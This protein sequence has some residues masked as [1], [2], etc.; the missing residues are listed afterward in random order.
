MKIQLEQV[1]YVQKGITVQVEQV[2]LYRALL[3]DFLI[4]LDWKWKVNVEVV[5]LDI[6]VEP[7]AWIRH[8]VC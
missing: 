1:V 7:Q 8:Q 3:E 5:L 2:T 6:I 4:L